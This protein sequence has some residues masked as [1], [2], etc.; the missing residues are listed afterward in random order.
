[1]SATRAAL[2][3]RYSDDKRSAASTEDQFRLCRELAQRR[4]AG[5]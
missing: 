2:Y 4:L 1:M 3:A 5:G